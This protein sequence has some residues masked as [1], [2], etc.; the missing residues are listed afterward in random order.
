MARESGACEGRDG[1][2]DG[3]MRQRVAA[4][5][6]H[7]G[8]QAGRQAM[9]EQFCSKMKRQ[10]AD[11]NE[12]ASKRSCLPAYCLLPAALE[13]VGS[14]GEGKKDLADDSDFGRKIQI[15]R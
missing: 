14:T 9:H 3:W 4:E 11:L 1:W 6:R 2:M 10:L 12:A 5:V 8:R 15:L 13:R 7:A